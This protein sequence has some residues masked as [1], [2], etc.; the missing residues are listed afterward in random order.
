MCGLWGET[1]F[2]TMIRC[3]LFYLMM[4]ESEKI[5]NDEACAVII[6]RRLGIQLKGVPREDP[7]A[8]RTA[9]QVCLSVIVFTGSSGWRCLQAHSHAP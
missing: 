3:G 9:R 2:E 6:R 8:T 5:S 7:W 1:C 4:C